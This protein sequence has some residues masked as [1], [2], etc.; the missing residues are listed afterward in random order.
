[1]VFLNPRLFTGMI[2]LAEEQAGFGLAFQVV[3]NS[4]NSN[5][6]HVHPI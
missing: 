5:F 3:F 1:M 2:G 6:P 4:S